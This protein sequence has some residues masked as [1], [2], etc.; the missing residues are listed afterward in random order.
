MTISYYDEIVM[1]HENNESQQYVKDKLTEI[2]I[3]DIFEPAWEKYSPKDLFEK[4]VFF[5]AYSYSW[6]SKLLI[7]G[8]DPKKYKANIASKLKL[9]KDITEELINYKDHSI[10][11]V[12]QHYLNLYKNNLDFTHLESLKLLYNNVMDDINNYK[13]KAEGSNNS[14][15]IDEKIKKMEKA[16]KMLGN[17]K[18]YE[19]KI[20]KEYRAILQPAEE[21]DENL[22]RKDNFQVTSLSIEESPSIKS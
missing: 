17:I 20:K 4:I 22:S 13:E 15:E 6:E 7:I 8:Q 21:L 2:G 9:P 11:L 1:M 10:T 16:D 3:F 12:F 14:D 18:R 5:T 19:E